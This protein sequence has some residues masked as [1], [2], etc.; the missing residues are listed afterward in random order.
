MILVLRFR[1]QLPGTYTPLLR[2]FIQTAF[3]YP[4]VIFQLLHLL[5][6]PPVLPQSFTNSALLI[7]C[8]HHNPTPSSSSD[9]ISFLLHEGH[10]HT[11][12]SP[13]FLF[14]LYLCIRGQL[15]QTES[16]LEPYLSAKLIYTFSISSLPLR[17]PYT[18]ASHHILHQFPGL[19]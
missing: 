17:H 9:H 5:L 18:S 4:L 3:P 10:I 6:Q 8:S 2:L 14:H 15:F 13:I 1:L 12:D 16:P 11:Y 7:T 19:S